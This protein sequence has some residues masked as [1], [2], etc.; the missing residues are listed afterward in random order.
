MQFNKHTHTHTYIASLFSCSRFLLPRRKKLTKFAR[1]PHPFVGFSFVFVFAGCWTSCCVSWRYS[2]GLTIEISHP[3]PSREAPRRR[4]GCHFPFF[5]IT[6][7]SAV[8][9]LTERLERDSLPPLSFF[10][11]P[12]ELEAGLVRSSERRGFRL[13]LRRW[14]NARRRSCKVCDL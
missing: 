3:P 2:I 13:P 14:A 7:D 1:K 11:Q 4:R 8:R 6:R 12:K 10:P 9:G 5:I